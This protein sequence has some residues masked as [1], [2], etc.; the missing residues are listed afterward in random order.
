MSDV[1]VGAPNPAGG[2]LA[3]GTL[4]QNR[5]RLE[6]LLAADEGSELYR[7]RELSTGGLVTVR[8]VPASAAL[9][10]DLPLSQQVNHRSACRILG[11]GLH[12]S[13]VFVAAEA[14]D[15][16]TLRQLIDAQRGQGQ[17]I[18][19]A[20]GGALLSHLLGA[21]AEIHK[22]LPHG[23]VTPDAIWIARSGRVMLSDLGIVRTVPSLAGR[24]G[25]AGMPAGLYAAPEIH[26]GGG[27]SVLADIYSIGAI[28]FEL[29]TGVPPTQPRHAPSVMVPGIPPVFDQ[30][31]ARALAPDPRARFSSADEFSA[32]LTAALGGGDP[33]A[34]APLPRNTAGRS[35]NVSAAAGLEGNAEKWLIQK[36][37]LDYGPFSIE[38]VQAQ[39][40]S[41]AFKP[42]DIIVDVDSG[43]RVRIKDH[44]QIGDFSLAAERS[45][46]QARRVQAENATVSSD[47]KKSGATVVILGAAALVVAAG[48]GLYLRN[49]KAAEEEA[50]AS[51]SG[52]SDIDAFVK[53]VK[54]DFQQARRKPARRGSGGGKGDEFSMDMNMGDVS[55][56]GGGGEEVLSDSV[57]QGVMMGNYRKLVPCVMDERRRSPGLSNIELDF[58]VQGAG[59]VSA[60]RVNGQSQGALPGCILGR[61]AAIAFP[62][63]NGKKT[64]ASWSMSMR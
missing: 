52:E 49:R 46:E 17:I 4:L 48:L 5:F 54:L 39:L 43:A 41:G 27:P 50:L 36:D 15:G 22:H 14:E 34:V 44:P 37:K 21:L 13:V 2:T 35:F 32:A 6:H 23:A 7:G 20:H 26:R 61:M 59:R 33:S 57:I 47:R 64:V 42:E 62:R 19:P 55:Q 53:E 51:R 16:H 1:Q 28:L 3:A 56:G 18:G 40:Q 9:Q 63:F 12:G 38:Q 8:L 30:V 29:L 45:R 25:P 60:V 10:Q 31:V 58:V 24:G 11:S